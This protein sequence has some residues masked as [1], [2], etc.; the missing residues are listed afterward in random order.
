LPY[1]AFDILLHPFVQEFKVK[2]PSKDE[3]QRK[4]KR[5]THHG[6]YK[7][8]AEASK[9]QGAPKVTRHQVAMANQRRAKSESTRINSPSSRHGE[10]KASIFA[11]ASTSLARRLKFLRAD[12]AETH[13]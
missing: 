7:G 8:E 13:W 12:V 4:I 9:R 6:K 5:S 11:M 10:W 2:T 3:K 1:Y